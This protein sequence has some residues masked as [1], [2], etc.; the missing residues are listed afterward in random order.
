LFQNYDFGAQARSES[1]SMFN[2]PF[3]LNRKE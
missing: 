1:P 3:S 2:F